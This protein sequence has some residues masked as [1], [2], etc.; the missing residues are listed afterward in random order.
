MNAGELKVNFGGLETA[1][2]DIQSSANQIRNRLDQLER[3][4]APLR[5]DWTGAAS[6]AYQVAKAEW[7]KAITDMQTLL[8]QLGQAVGQSNQ[9]YQGAERANQGRW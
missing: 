7:D 6:E 4:L 5:A 1:A 2:A 3:E 9:E 8:Q